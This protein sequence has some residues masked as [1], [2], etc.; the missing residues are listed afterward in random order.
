MA[1]RAGI[2]KLAGVLTAV[3]GLALAPLP[4]VRAL[5]AT[6]P[7]VCPGGEPTSIT[8]G[9]L[10]DIQ[11]VVPQHL[12][13][14]NEHQREILRFSNLIANTGDGPWRMRPE[15]PLPDSVPG[16]KQ[17]AFQQILTSSDSSGSVVCE[18]DAS[19]FTYHPTHRHWHTEG[20][21]EFEVRVGS[22]GGDPFVN[23]LG[24]QVK[25]KTT[26]C[27]IDWVKLV[28]SSTSGKNSTRT[29]FDCAGPFHGVSVDWTDQYH[30]ATDD[31]DVD[32][33]G[34]K[35]GVTYYLFSTTNAAHNF[36][37]KDYTNNSAWQAFTVTRDSRGNP[38]IVLGLP[39][40]CTP[41]TGLCGEQTA[42][43]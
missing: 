1:T 25:V 10:P 30:H 43:R 22:P 13:L 17:K 19:A 3:A 28:G 33:T 5:A 29:Y 21:A 12:N 11:T 36:I 37:E 18:K 24:D 42:N 2:T 34:V 26:F 41:G 31:Q 15:F 4:P 40:P 38:K 7:A 16:T 23:D 32:I 35:E 8:G 27:L 20:V 6:P 39:S 9:L 14:V